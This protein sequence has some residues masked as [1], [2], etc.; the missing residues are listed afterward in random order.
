MKATDLAEKI[1]T[2]P[3][4]AAR[5]V[6]SLLARKI[7]AAYTIQYD[8]RAV[9]YERYMCFISTG[10]A[11]TEQSKAILNFCANC[12]NVTYLIHGIGHYDYII[13]ISAKGHDELTEVLDRIE[14]V[15][16][17]SK[18][19]VDPMFVKDVWYGERILASAGSMEIILPEKGEQRHRQHS[20][21]P[22]PSL[23]EYYGEKE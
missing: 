9:G 1:G 15:L 18:V 2:S 10:A 13:D 19:R 16:S 17:D 5:M 8:H 12:R 14:E 4:T 20:T 3:D 23:M 22:A 11:T 7:V 21:Y 6:K